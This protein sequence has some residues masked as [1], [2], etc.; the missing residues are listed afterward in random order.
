M[1]NQTLNRKFETTVVCLLA[2]FVLMLSGCVPEEK[3]DKSAGTTTT[4]AG[5]R[6]VYSNGFFDEERDGTNSW[7]WM[8]PTGVARL[9]N[10]G[11]DME[12]VVAG[13]PPMEQFKQAP[14]ITITLN[15]TKLDEY[16]GSNDVATRT[17][18]VTPAQQ[19]DGE[20]SELKISSDMSFVPKEVEK[21]SNDGRRLAFYLT[22]LTWKLK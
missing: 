6:V 14:M 20:W 12:L 2:A 22:G 17:F 11:K 9:R 7:R 16:K 5:P 3:D 18:T 8:E 10:T 13:R 1:L 15:G 21:T 4:P 19:G